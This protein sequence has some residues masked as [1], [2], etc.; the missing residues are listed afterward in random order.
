MTSQTN[1]SEK[2]EPTKYYIDIETTPCHLDSQE[3]HNINHTEEV[4]IGSEQGTTFPTRVGTTMCNAL[5]DI[6]ATRCCMSEEYFKKLQLSKIH[7]L[8][9]VNVRSATGSN[10][11]PIGLV[12]CT[13]MLGDTSFDF[14][15]MVCKNLTRPLILG[16]HFL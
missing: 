13:F 5:I 15:C 7:L 6:G 12:N 11:A 1:T 10:L 8:Q 2:Y 3:E 14:D 16:R 9:N 4:I